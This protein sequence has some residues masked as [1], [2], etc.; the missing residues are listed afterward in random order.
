[1]PILR[2]HKVT[3]ADLAALDAAAHLGDHEHAA[4]IEDQI[5]ALP[6]HARQAAA[7]LRA[8]AERF[9]AI[10]PATVCKPDGLTFASAPSMLARLALKLESG[11]AEQIA[12][13]VQQVRRI[14]QAW[15]DR[16]SPA[17]L[18]WGEAVAAVAGMG[19][20]GAAESPAAPWVA[21][22]RGEREKGRVEERARIAEWC[23]ARAKEA[24]READEWGKISDMESACG[25]EGER[26]AFRKVAAYLR[27]KESA[28]E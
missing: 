28:D 1:M 20:E 19:E 11:A 9:A 24:Q 13:G 17:A 6:S 2:G 22:M 8:V 5:H 10:V 18:L 3:P 12:L 14:G 7:T 23:D 16:D 25:Q 21:L 15:V 27:G 4:Q 26:D